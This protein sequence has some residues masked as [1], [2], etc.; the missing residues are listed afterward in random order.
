MDY[1]KRDISFQIKRERIKIRTKTQLL[2]YPGYLY[3]QTHK[4]LIVQN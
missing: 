3:A 4:K 1:Y 2:Q